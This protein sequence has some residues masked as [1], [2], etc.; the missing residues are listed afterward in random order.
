MTRSQPV[1]FW[2]ACRSFVSRGHHLAGCFSLKRLDLR[3]GERFDLRANTIECAGLHLRI[4][5]GEVGRELFEHRRGEDT[6][7]FEQHA[8]F[9]QGGGFADFMPAEDDLVPPRQ[10]QAGEFGK[11]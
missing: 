4:E 5:R 1:A 10:F 6:R 3:T 8:G 7:L 2:K 9:R 11:C